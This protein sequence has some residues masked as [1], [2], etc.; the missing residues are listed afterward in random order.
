MAL[1]T[2]PPRVS[3]SAAVMDRQN[4]LPALEL[5]GDLRL[6]PQ[7]VARPRN[8]QGL[9]HRIE[10]RWRQ[11]GVLKAESG[12]VVWKIGVVFFT[13]ETL[14]LRGGNNFPVHH[15]RGSG[16]VVICRKPENVAWRGHRSQEG[17]ER[18]GDAGTGGKN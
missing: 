13:G 7:M 3:K 11:A 8:L 6:N 17:I 16:V 15:Q 2:R 9:P 4:T 14:L 10:L 12:C 18:P 5:N 1:A